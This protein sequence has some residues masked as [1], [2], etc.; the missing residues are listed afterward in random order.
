MH[1][2]VFA[3]TDSSSSG[4]A[5]FQLLF[6]AVIGLAMYLVLIRPQRRRMREAQSLLSQ[7]S[8]GDEVITTGGIYGFIS[9]IDGDT[10]WLDIAENVEIRL[11][12]SAVSRK[13][14]P[15]KEPAGGPV[16]ETPDAPSD[17]PD[18]SEQ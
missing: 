14:D 1:A 8:E 5:L 9:A 16:P 15:S 3:S 2:S 12:R 17:G 6:F 11:H 18:A 13:I 10:L 4:S 7:L